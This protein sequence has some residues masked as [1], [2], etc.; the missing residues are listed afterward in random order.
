MMQE[1]LRVVWP[2]SANDSSMTSKFIR[3]DRL[4]NAIKTSELSDGSVL[5]DLNLA[6][7][8]G[9]YFSSTRPFYEKA[10]TYVL[11]AMQTPN[12]THL[13]DYLI[14]N[15]NKRQLSWHNDRVFMEYVRNVAGEEDML[16]AEVLEVKDGKIIASRVY[17]G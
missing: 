5:N 2:A 17:H 13:D 3:P 4:F 6:E 8:Q 14:L 1:A 15:P 7:R 10:I 12:F 16:V 11:A 9:F